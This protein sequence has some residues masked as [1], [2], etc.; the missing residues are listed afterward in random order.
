[1]RCDL[2]ILCGGKRDPGKSYATTYK[3]WVP[4]QPRPWRKSCDGESCN[5]D[6]VCPKASVLITTHGP[7]EDLLQ[8]TMCLP[9]RESRSTA[10]QHEGER[11]E[12]PTHAGRRDLSE[13]DG[14][15]CCKACDAKPP[16][17]V[18]N[19]STG[20]VGVEGL[21]RRALRAEEADR[22]S[23]SKSRTCIS[24]TI[25]EAVQGRQGWTRRPTCT[26]GRCRLLLARRASHS[27]RARSLDG[28]RTCDRLRR[29]STLA[30]TS[31][32]R[33]QM[34]T[35]TGSASHFG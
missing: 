13:G 15:Q 12:L 16:T 23:A 19:E 3:K 17:R 21:G 22:K 5:G 11:Q 34:C 30:R 6:R 31:S 33:H 4:E 14:S 7:R 10:G 8:K 24:P 2:K 18:S 28:T 27:S 26:A 25:Q 29:S 9:E 35:G 1:M 20:N 32:H